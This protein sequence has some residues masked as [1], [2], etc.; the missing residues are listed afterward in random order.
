MAAESEE[1][2]DQIADD[3]FENKISIDEFLDQFKIS[4]TEMHLRKLKA[5]KMQELLR[6][7]AHRSNPSNPQ[8]SNFPTSTGFYGP[9][10]YP[11]NMPAFPMPMMRPSY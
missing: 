2:S 6:R 1:K 10:P 11:T 9:A 5:E 8:I 7:G 3:L 4:R